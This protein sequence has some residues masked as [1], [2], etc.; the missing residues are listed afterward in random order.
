DDQPLRSLRFKDNYALSAARAEAVA[1]LLGQRLSVPGRIESAGAGDSQPVA[2][3][4]DLAANRTRNR[5]VEIL[6]QPGE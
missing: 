2:V 3:P 4:P 1:Q 6:F 5:R